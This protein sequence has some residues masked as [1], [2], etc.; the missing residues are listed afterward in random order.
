MTTVGLSQVAGQAAREP[1]GAGLNFLWLELTNR[2]NLK[3]V[4]CYTLPQD[5]VHRRRASA[6][7]RTS[8]RLLAASKEIGFEFVEVFTNLTLLDEETVRLARSA[9]IRF[10]HVG[11]LRQA[12]GAPGHTRNGSSHARTIKN[13]KHLID[14]EVV[15]APA[16]IQID[17]ET[18][19]SKARSASSPTSACGISEGRACARSARRGGHVAADP[20][21][22]AV[23][24]LLSGRLCVAPDGDA[25][26]A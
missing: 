7:P 11:V 8:N 19:E 1:L 26:R 2:C 23:R 20:D 6:Q 5:A 24:S 13:L 17:Q 25:Y 12:R 21:V 22:G 3:C 4:H 18:A 14:S 16:V 15:T 9:D 10:G